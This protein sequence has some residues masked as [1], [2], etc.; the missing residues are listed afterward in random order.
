M[1]W[2]GM[3]PFHPI[4]VYPRNEQT[5]IFVLGRKPFMQRI[6]SSKQFVHVSIF[7]IKVWDSFYVEGTKTVHTK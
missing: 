7:S 1:E 2:D 5:L 6:R 4:L 3:E